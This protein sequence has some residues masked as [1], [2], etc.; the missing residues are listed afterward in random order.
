MWRDLRDNAPD[1]WADAVEVDR[2]IRDG[3]NMRGIKA[4]L[5]PKGI[6]NPGKL[7]RN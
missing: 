2:V 7:F 3:G 6:L 5:D 1:E 4:Q